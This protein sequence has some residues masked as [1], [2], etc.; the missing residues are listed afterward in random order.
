VG[1]SWVTV[2]TGTFGDESW[3]RLARE[4]AGASVPAGVPWIHV[5]GDTIAAARNAALARVESAF[6]IGLDAD[7]QL[8]GIEYIEAMARG[9]ADVRVPLVTYV[10]DG[11][12]QRPWQ[13]RVAGHTHDCVADCLEAGNWVPIGACARTSLLRTVGFHDFGWSEDWATWAFAARAGASFELIRDAVY[14]AHVDTAGRNRGQSREARDAAHWEIH[15]TVWPER[16]A[17]AT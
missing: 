14:V 1:V 7:D 16:Y 10:R 6:V 13:P 15:R 11:R 5:H 9:T 17:E 2:T 3:Q 12:A 4:R 8:P